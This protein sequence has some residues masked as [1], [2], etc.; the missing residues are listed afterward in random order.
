MLSSVRR[1]K[2][3]ATL[4]PSTDRPLVL[5][6]I[7]AAGVNVVRLNFSHGDHE[8]HGRRIR[9]VRAA[10]RT[11]GRPIAILMDLQGPKIR[12]GILEGAKQVRLREGQELTLTTRKLIGNASTVSVTYAA[13]PQ[14]VQLDE[15]IL[16]DDGA[17]ELR[18]ID[19]N[20]TDVRT[21]I[22]RGGILGEHKGLNLPGLRRGE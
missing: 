2:I 13:L 6:K 15:R 9:R 1:T 18:V 20:D 11:V 16:V 17:L 8:A 4:G 10:A 19:R 14:E 22:V 3:V 7:L 21:R 12:T 5:E